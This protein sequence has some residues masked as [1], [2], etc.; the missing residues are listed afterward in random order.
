MN[1]LAYGNIARNIYT[2]WKHR[3]LSIVDY[4]ENNMKKAL[5][6]TKMYMMNEI[7]DDASQGAKFRRFYYNELNTIHTFNRPIYNYE[8]KLMLEDEGFEVL[9]EKDSFVVRWIQEELK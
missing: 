4:Q 1:T 7:C 5:L 6:N 8:V 2:K 9:Y 3:Q